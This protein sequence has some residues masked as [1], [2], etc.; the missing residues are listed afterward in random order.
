MFEIIMSNL[1]LLKSAAIKIYNTYMSV[2][3]NNVYYNFFFLNPKAK[4][5]K[6]KRMTS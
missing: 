3:G 5:V 2:I 6:E 4:L 1:S